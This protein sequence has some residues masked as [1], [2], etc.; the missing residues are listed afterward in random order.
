MAKCAELSS[1][2]EYCTCS[3]EPC[4]RKGNCCAC[5]KYHNDK[6]EVP[7]CLFD[8]EAEKTYDRSVAKFIASQS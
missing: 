6:G 8:E 5:V 2:Q 4:P 3:Y 7:G 1:N